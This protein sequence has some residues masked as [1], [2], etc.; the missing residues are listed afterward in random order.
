M[1]RSL[2]EAS[3][4]QMELEEAAISEKMDLE[5]LHAEANDPNGVLIFANGAL[6]GQKVRQRQNPG[7]AREQ[8]LLA[9]ADRAQLRAMSGVNERTAAC[10]VRPRAASRWTPRP[11][12]AACRPQPCSTNSSWRASK[13]ASSP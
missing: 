4:N 2:F 11:S 13:R 5:E 12:A 10:T 6:S 1:A 9:E 8:I 7:A 3:F